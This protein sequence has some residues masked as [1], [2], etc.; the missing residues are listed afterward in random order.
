MNI[1]AVAFIDPFDLAASLRRRLGLFQGEGLRK[2]LP[3][4]G[5]KRGADPDDDTL[6]VWS[7]ERE[8][9]GELSAM[10]GHLAHTQDILW[11]RIEL[12]MLMPGGIVPWARDQTP[13]GQRFTRAHVAL[14]TNPSAMNFV[15]GT[16]VNMAAGVVNLIDRTLPCSAI[17]LG[18]TSR[19]HLI[20]DFRK[21]ETVE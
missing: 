13:Y 18:E 7:K 8:R 17:N 12:E 15:G 16:A 3:L 21:K 11:G 5:P 2:M 6:F 20:V 14:R 9:W 10:L 1:A 4:R 19:V